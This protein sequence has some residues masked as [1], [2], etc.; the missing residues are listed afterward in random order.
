MFCNIKH[1]LGDPAVL[2]IMAYSE[3]ECSPERAARKARAYQENPAQ[4]SYGWMEDEAV[5]V[6]IICHCLDRWLV[7]CITSFEN[8]KR[9]KQIA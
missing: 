6:A 2:R 3:Y 4:R 7:H 9:P 1:R 5:L 8:K